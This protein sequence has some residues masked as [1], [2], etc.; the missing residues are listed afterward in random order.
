[1]SPLLVSQ[2]IAVST[3]LFLFTASVEDL[4]F[5][6]EL[7]VVSQDIDE[8]DAG[9]VSPTPEVQDFEDLPEDDEAAFEGLVRDSQDLQEREPSPPAKRSKPEPQVI[10][11]AAEFDF[12]ADRETSPP[13]KTRDFPAPSSPSEDGVESSS[14]PVKG[15]TLEQVEEP[16]PV[17]EQGQAPPVTITTT[18]TPRQPQPADHQVR[19]TVLLPPTI[20]GRCARADSMKGTKKADGG[21]NCCTLL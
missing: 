1:M 6:D 18:T 8:E 9:A 21:R 11:E 13:L 12:W 5:D 15:L 10:E 17:A 2:F 3:F 16:S 7:R 14:P 20:R 4:L 19:R